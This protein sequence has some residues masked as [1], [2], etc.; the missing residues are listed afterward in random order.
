[1]YD[2]I[3]ITN[4]LLCEGDFYSRIEN[5]ARAEPKAI[6]LREKDLPEG[7]YLAMASKV[8]EI[9]D[10]HKCE[11]IVHNFPDVALHLGVGNL[12][13]P[14]YKLRELPPQE[15]RKFQLLGSS[16]HSA[17]ELR[18]A[19]SLGA[20]YIIFGH[21]FETDCKKGLEPRGLDSLKAVCESTQLPV[22]AIGGIG[23]GNIAEVK[24][25]G[26]KGSCLMSSLMLC[27]DVRTY[28]EYLGEGDEAR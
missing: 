20:N 12:H 7:E 9:C 4:R 21:I 24:K 14:L 17:E 16:C 2:I 15:R 26:A 3:A 13:L 23:R 11:L 18:E 19:E 6:L 22:Y 27:E 8:K 10:L 28:L 5:I 1:M 25:A